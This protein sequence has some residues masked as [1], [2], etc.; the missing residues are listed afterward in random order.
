MLKIVHIASSDLGGAAISCIRLH[1]ALLEMGVDSKLL[2]ISKNKK[3]IINHFAYP[4]KKITLWDKV[5]NRLQFSEPSYIKHE[6]YLLNKVTGY[7][8]FSFPESEY[9]LHNL[10]L[11]QNA[12]VI[13]LHWVSGFIDYSSFFKKIKKP[14]VWTLHDM[15]A[16][17]GGC[18]YSSGCTKYTNDC[19][20]CPQLEG[21]IN[22]TISRQNLSVKQDSLIK[23]DLTVVTPSVWLKKCAEKSTILKTKAI[24]VI[25]YS[26][27]LAIFKP[28]N[29]AD[30]R[31]KLRL[32]LDTKVILFVSQSVQNKRKGFDLL[33]KSISLLS[34]SDKFVICSVGQ[35]NE[36]PENYIS[37][38]EIQKEEQMALAYN[39]ADVFVLP[40]KEDNLPNVVMESIA[41][42]V[43]VIG[44]DIG[45]MPDMI[46]HN[47]N[48]LLCKDLD[49]LELSKT[50]AH[51]F[52]GDVK[53]DREEI[54]KDAEIRYNNTLQ[55]KAYFSLYKQMVLKQN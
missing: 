31:M 25:P 52:S 9:P 12:D 17:T 14:I 44:F 19:N 20:I 13:N 3:R 49:P 18:H 26:L 15:N 22:P 10:E 27:D 53:F 43:P 42:G 7:E 2:T 23:S 55:A 47:F 4:D 39:A 8:Y 50:I 46:K 35:M 16:F 51:F 48:G 29:Q 30:A 5:K 28:M 40:S 36:V 11:L 21:T 6:K 32:P 34:A 37:L 1:Q 33:L 45:G 41:C 54:R 38:G 24:H